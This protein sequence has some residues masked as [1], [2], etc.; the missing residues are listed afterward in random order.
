MRDTV[1]SIGDLAR[2]TGVGVETIRYYERT[3][4]LPKPS[5]TSGNYRA[6]YAADLARLGF[7]RRARELGFPIEDVRA[8]LGLSD[9]RDRPCEAVDAIAREHLAGVDRRLADLATLRREL[10]ALI[11]GCSRGTMAECRILE[12]LAPPP[13]AVPSNI[14]PASPEEVPS[15]GSSPSSPQSPA[16]SRSQTTAPPPARARTRAARPGRLP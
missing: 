11:E 6:Y 15:S 16:L 4:L 9:R 13:E 7:V 3:G 8:L 14:A 10:A 2:A 5:R 1:L 12:A